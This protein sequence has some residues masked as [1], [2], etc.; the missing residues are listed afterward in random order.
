MS[1]LKLPE[2]K[3]RSA[4]SGIN[5]TISLGGDIVGVLR[6]VSP[7]GRRPL[8]V[9]IDERHT[10]QLGGSSL[11]ARQLRRLRASPMAV[12]SFQA[13]RKIIFI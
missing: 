13:Y 7:D 9:E 8:D 12:G 1:G 10:G 3:P 5:L 2:T 11:K 4:T 6:E